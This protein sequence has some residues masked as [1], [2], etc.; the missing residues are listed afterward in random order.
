MDEVQKH[1][2]SKPS[3]THER[4]LYVFCLGGGGGG[5]CPVMGHILYLCYSDNISSYIVLIFR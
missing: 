5:T 3:G 4:S 1:N 2:S